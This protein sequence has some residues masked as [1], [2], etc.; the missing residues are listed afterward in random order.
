[1][2]LKWDCQGRG[3][4]PCWCIEVL[5]QYLSVMIGETPNNLSEDADFRSQESKPELPEAVTLEIMNRS[6]R[7]VFS[8]LYVGLCM[9][10][11][12]IGPI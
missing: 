4:K 8:S 6:W 2:V 3:E 9:Q 5:A 12:C 7:L 11:F 1:M 10:L